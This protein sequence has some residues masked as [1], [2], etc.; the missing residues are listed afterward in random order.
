M[1]EEIGSE[2]WVKERARFANIFP[3]TYKT[4]RFNTF[5]ETPNNKKALEASRAF[6]DT[7]L[8]LRQGEATE[9]YPFLL[10]YGP[11]GTGKTHLLY[12]ILWDILERDINAAYFQ[13]EEM[14][15][16]LRAG[17]ENNRGISSWTYDERLNFIKKVPMLAIDDIGAHSETAWSTAKLDMMVD[18]RYRSEGALIIATN[19]PLKI[20]PPRIMD[21]LKEGWSAGIEGESWRGK[22]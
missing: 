7:F 20:I 3:K 10:L 1:S 2:E 13:A 5:Q 19:G 18:Y 16:E 14:L 22:R 4:Q 6:I 15:D 12:T 21:R 8:K 17:F 9:R 11:R